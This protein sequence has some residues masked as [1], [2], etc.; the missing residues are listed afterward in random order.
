M[1]YFTIQELCHT[2]T[3]IINIPD[4][5]SISNLEFLVDSILDKIRE[6]FGK[7][8]TINCGYRSQNVNE[9][10]GGKSTSQHLKGEAVDITSSDNETLFKI[11][12]KYNFDQ[13]ID[14][15]DLS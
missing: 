1:K 11:C 10:V 6:E 5:Q 8:I 3:G 14:E 15:R 7:P 4:E 2:N 12:K 9:K 13:L